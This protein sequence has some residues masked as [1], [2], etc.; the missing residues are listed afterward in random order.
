MFDIKM[1]LTRQAHFV[2]HGHTTDT[3]MSMTY[4]SV[5]SQD[6]ICIALMLASLNDLEV[7]SCDISK[8]D[9]D[10]ASTYS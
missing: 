4:S 5:V 2:A 7:L 3:P 6:S 8:L 9:E 10:G 1:D